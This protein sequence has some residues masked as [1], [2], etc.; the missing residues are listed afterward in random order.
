LIV[1]F[2]HPLRP[3]PSNQG[4]PG[5]KVRKGL[6]TDKIAEAEVI[7]TDLN[8]LLADTAFHSPAARMKAESTFDPR[9]VEIFYDG[10]EPKKH[11]YRLLRDEQLP[12]PSRDDGYPRILLIGTPG[13]GKTT[14]VR[15]MIGTDPERERFPSTS[16]NRTTTC[17]TEVI[18]GQDSYSAAITFLSEEETDFEIRQNVSAALLR[19]INSDNDAKIAE[20][21]L[22][23]SDGR[24]RLKY[25]LGDWPS[26]DQEDDPYSVQSEALPDISAES[27]LVVSDVEACELGDRLRGYV[28]A[29][30]VIAAQHKA[31]V[32]KLQGPLD[33]LGTE[34][35]NTALDLIQEL[36]EN[37]AAYATLVSDILDDIRSKFDIM[38]DG[39][40]L[41]TTTGWPRMWTMDV[42]QEDRGLFIDSVR[43]FSGI[44]R[45]SWGRLF[46]PLVNGIRVAGPFKPNW[47]PSNRLPKLVL[48]DTEG[49]GHKANT[50]PDV[51]DYIVSRF[52][53]C[54]AIILVHR[55]DTPFSFDGGKALE[56]IG[57]AGETSKVFVVFSRMDEVKGDNIK[58]WQAKRDF[59]FSGI[60][61]VLDNQIAKSL[62][63]DVARFMLAHFEKNA[64]YLGA[65]QAADPVPAKTELLELLRRLVSIVPPPIPARAF[66]RHNYDFLVLA[67]QKGV[68]DFRLPWRARLGIDRRSDVRPLPWQ[69]VKAVSKRYA[70]G[71]DDGYP[72]RPASNL[73]SALSLA[74][75]RFIENPTGWDGDASDEEKRLILDRIKASVI[76]ALLGFCPNQ[77]REKAQPLWQEAFAL[78]GTG[79]T[80]DRKMKIEA[81]YERW[82]PI[83]AG[84]SSNMQYVQEFIESLKDLVK[85]AIEQARIALDA[86]SRTR[87][88]CA[89][90]EPDKGEIP[91][92]PLE[93][94]K[95]EEYHGK[96]LA[97]MKA[98][99]AWALANNAK[100]T[101]G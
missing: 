53:E 49:L 96:P 64:F 86:E 61:N 55:G 84:E 29:L 14:L 90:P 21:L 47:A 8:R 34:E 20:S 39:K 38:V 82:V 6:G 30:R 44:D 95:K 23:P 94:P 100:E 60:R 9:A 26:A 56:A 74:V 99:A 75:G 2:R 28:A 93:E 16:V 77:L 46:T 59:T 12:F 51:P 71:Y 31:E 57:G 19:A 22:E 27:P 70:E 4:K 13:A 40:I 5:R 32:E 58:G 68:E 3:D 67:L 50:T 101:K 88:G 85:N 7:V 48:I 73:L 11:G 24:F 43:F 72:I 91:D 87:D 62:T 54:D 42:Q 92:Y 80:F 63:P 1:D 18:V 37:D 79:T 17:E 66:P 33:S 97:Y 25:L 81:L 45:R 69:S 10:L 65:L 76:A 36:A 52:S 78:R 41:K 83:P 35:R 15:Q 98:K 89:E